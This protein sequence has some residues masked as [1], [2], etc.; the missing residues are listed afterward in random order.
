MHYEHNYIMTTRSHQRHASR[1]TINLNMLKVG[2]C[3]NTKTIKYL[4]AQF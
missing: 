3:L 1:I 2:N 4:P